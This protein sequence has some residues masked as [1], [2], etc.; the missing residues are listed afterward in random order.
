MNLEN[1]TA[2]IRP[3]PPYKALD[4]G[5]AIARAWFLPLWGLWLK[6]LFRWSMLIWVCLFA[7]RAVMSDNIP[8]YFILFALLI[9]LFK[10][11]L[12]YNLLIFLSQKLFDVKM[13]SQNFNPY[14]SLTIQQKLALFFSRIGSNRI[15]TMAVMHLESQ[16]GKAKKT[17][18]K[19]LSYGGGNA[20]IGALIVFW[21]I[22][23]SL[24]VGG[25]VFLVELFDFDVL[26]YQRENWIFE[27]QELPSWFMAICFL[28]F[29]LIQSLL[30]PFFVASSFAFYVCRRSL[31]EGWDI[32]LSF[33]HLMGRFEQS[34]AGEA[35]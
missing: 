9:W 7:Y 4:L 24:V 26:G 5:F 31:L 19:Q 3:L 18:L 12:E 15:L 21:L 30:T 28:L 32:E 23:W 8:L 14:H 35:R 20:L 33:R 11:L 1:L 34:Q 16:T 6:G 27:A 17:R 2:N 10:P 25:F 29:V 13:S 22:E